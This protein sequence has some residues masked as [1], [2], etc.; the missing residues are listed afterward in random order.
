MHLTT[1]QI[2]TIIKTAEITFNKTNNRKSTEVQIN[3]ATTLLN[4]W[5]RHHSHYSQNPSTGTI[6]INDLDWSY[7]LKKEELILVK[8]MSWDEIFI[9]IE[10]LFK[11]IDIHLREVNNLESQLRTAPSYAQLHREIQDL[12]GQIASLKEEFKIIN[13]QLIKNQESSK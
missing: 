5:I 2:D 13:K 10:N 3:I 8:T 12:R 9:V 7:Q 1:S 4:E 6:R 11:S